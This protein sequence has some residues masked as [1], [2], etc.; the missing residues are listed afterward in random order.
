MGLDTSKKINRITVNG[1]DMRVAGVPDLQDKL[2]KENGTY[3]HDT[4]YEG[5]GT[6][7]VDVQPPLLTKEFREN[8]TFKASDEGYYGYSEITIKVAGD[9]GVP[10]PN[11]TMYEMREADYM[12][13]LQGQISIYDVPSEAEYLEQ[14][15]Y[16]NSAIAIIMGEE[17]NG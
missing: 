9:G 11:E 10:E 14:Q 8:G 3:K 15:E 7:D 5:F 2:I 1:V 17:F 6:I 13:Y 16:V 12:R 4:G